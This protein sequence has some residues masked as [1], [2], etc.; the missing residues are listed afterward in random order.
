MFFAVV[1]C[2]VRR[3]A[4][5]GVTDQ[6]VGRRI[7][8]DKYIDIIGSLQPHVSRLNHRLILVTNVYA[9]LPAM[10]SI[11]RITEM[12]HHQLVA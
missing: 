3:L 10:C 5:I 9:I 11:H 8:R 7:D 1:H 12:Y 4:V 2:T 6:Y